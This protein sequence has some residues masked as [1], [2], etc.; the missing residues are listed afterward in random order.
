MSVPL[1]TTPEADSQIRIID[2]WWCEHRSAVPDLFIN[3]LSA[4]FDVIGHTPQVGR[5]Y[6]R[7]PVVG[8]RR[9]LLSRTRY[10]VYYVPRNEEVWVAAAIDSTCPHLAR[11]PL[12][13]SR[14]F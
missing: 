1:R 11:R 5:S 9:V 8:T 4:A 6:R 3:E 7:A 10:H 13:A 2:A 12:T 14:G